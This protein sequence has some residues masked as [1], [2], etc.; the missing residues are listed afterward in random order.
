M[1]RRDRR[2]DEK[3]EG[4]ARS[5]EQRQ[6]D[7]R[8]VGL[9]DKARAALDAGDTMTAEVEVRAALR[10]VPDHPQASHL[11]AVV[12]YHTGRLDD[13]GDHIVTAALGDDDDAAI[14]A[15]C[16]VI[17]TLMGRPQEA[18]AASRHAIELDDSLAVAHSS[19]GAAL[20]AQQ[21]GDEALEALQA[22]LDRDPDLVEAWVHRGNLEV[23][24]GRAV[25]AVEAYA[26]AASREPDNA[27]V[28]ANM[29]VA[30][31]LAGDL[32]AAEEQCRIALELDP[33]CAEAHN[34][35]GQVLREM[36]E[37]AAA[38]E[39]FRRAI[40]VREGFIMAQA[41][42]AGMLFKI[43]DLAAAEAEYR[44]IIET[45]EV[46]AG[47][48]VGLGVVLLAAGRL[49]DAVVAFR[50]AVAHQPG[51]GEAWANLAAAL[52]AE[53]SDADLDLIERTLEDQR[54]P[55][56]DR[57]GLNFAQGEALERKGRHAEAFEAF[58][59]GNDLKR[60]EMATD[61]LTFDREAFD[62]RVS[63]IIS[64]FDASFIER[65]KQG[66]RG[67]ARP[68][69]I[70]GMPRSGTT[71]VEQ[72]IASHPEAVGLGETNGI[73]FQV[74]FFPEGAD[75]YTADDVTGF[76][77]GYLTDLEDRIGDAKR[78]ADKTPFDFLMLGMIHSMFPN[79]TLIHC[80]RDARDMGLSAFFQDF[81]V[82]HP[83]ATTLEDIAHTIRAHNR[84]ME[85]W[86]GLLG[87][88][89]LQIA[90]EHVVADQERQSRRL[91][92]HLGLDWNA[93]CLDFHRNGQTVL[94][95]SNW[96]VRKP[97]YTGAVER[98]R[99]HEDRLG[100]LAKL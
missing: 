13:A 15:D 84:I 94:T 87:G 54:I 99:A 5:A 55:A 18:E 22:A 20:A 79:A 36:E 30:L 60:D 96:Q 45:H 57:I 77:D 88:R 26:E 14:H 98:W 25:E 62:E 17:M 80:T 97:I 83:W 81:S 23:Q 89:L 43:G 50:D 16:G 100:P 68:V 29:G 35:L 3:L 90:Y 32:E 7:A 73:G 59:V 92:E 1:S 21:R 53:L 63:E 6:L 12:C 33:D 2:R 91:I 48:H 72:I 19:L 85:H 47:A 76:A 61:G 74:G 41:N 70:V 69:F 34:G 4:Q 82:P 58:R 8:L 93:A 95:A 78:F 67:D 42:L 65:L 64:S 66:G 51:N 46:F 28:R 52:G 75:D 9:L 40:A 44:A 86:R 56:A 11:L 10:D 31:R 71:L 39:A 37:P 24:E 49:D 27:I 38:M